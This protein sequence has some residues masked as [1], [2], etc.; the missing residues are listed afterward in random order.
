MIMQGELPW[1]KYSSSHRALAFEYGGTWFVLDSN[2]KYGYRKTYYENFLKEYKVISERYFYK[3]LNEKEFKKWAKSHEGK[4]YDYCDVFGLLLKILGFISFN[5]Y[6]YDFKKLKCNEV[7]LSFAQD[8]LNIKIG[9]PD[10]WDLKKTDELVLKIIEG[11]Y[12]QVK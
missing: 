5:Y 1:S 9:D 8:I 4:K 10:N 2:G 7:F 3:Q 6:G 12:N 11:N